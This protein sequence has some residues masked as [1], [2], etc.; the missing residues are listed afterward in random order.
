MDKPR[1]SLI[2][3]EQ[4]AET[5]AML[6]RAFV[7]DPL[8]V[9]IVGKIT[10]TSQRA[11]RIG[12]LFKVVL[13]SHRHEGQPVIGV[14]KGERVAA[15]AIVEYVTRPGATAIIV[16]GGLTLLPEL[17]KAAGFAGVVR[18]ISTLDTLS[19][20]RPTEPHIYLNI[21]GVE[22]E[23]QRRH[24][25][26]AILD[27]LREQAS[28]R[29]DF[30]GVYLETATESNLAYYGH[31]GYTVLSEIYPLGVRMWRMLQPCAAAPPK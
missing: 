1:I 16:M 18:A 9:A 30:S 15:A 24:F 27:F 10:D 28:L 2:F 12:H 6:G 29:N 23:F 11:T 4:Y 14:M 3:P 20:N 26:V 13:R 21:L 5:A 8:L 31:I 25:G 19:R 7:D 22:P 17:F